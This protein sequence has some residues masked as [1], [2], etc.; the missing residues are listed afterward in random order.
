VILSDIIGVKV[1]LNA[2]THLFLV[3][4]YKLWIGFFLFVF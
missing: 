4:F 1:T 2:E 3:I